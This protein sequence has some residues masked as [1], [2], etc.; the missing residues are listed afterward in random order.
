MSL[1]DK[2]LELLGI[3]GP[4]MGYDTIKEPGTTQPPLDEGQKKLMEEF[5]LLRGEANVEDNIDQY[6]VSK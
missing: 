4:E 5:Q 3:G 2:L 1:V 6:I